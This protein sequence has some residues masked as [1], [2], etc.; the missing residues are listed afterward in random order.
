MPLL[1][2]VPWYLDADGD[3]Y[4]DLAQVVATSS[5]PVPGASAAGSDCDDANASFHPHGAEVCDDGFDQDCDGQDQACVGLGPVGSSGTQVR[6]PAYAGLGASIEAA[7]LDGD[8]VDELL[9]GTQDWRG[10]PAYVSVNRTDVTSDAVARLPQW[11]SRAYGLDLNRDGSAELVLTNEDVNGFGL[12]GSVASPEPLHE[13]HSTQ[14]V[15][16]VEAAD[17]TGDGVPELAVSTWSGVQG[18]LTVFEDPLGAMEVLDTLSL[19]TR[20][21]GHAADLDGDGIADWLDGTGCWWQ[22]P[23]PLRDWL[24]CA[25]TTTAIA[26]DADG[27]GRPDVIGAVGNAVWVIP[28]PDRT[29]WATI[30]LHEAAASLDWLVDANASGRPWV[31]VSE[32]SGTIRY[33]EPIPGPGTWEPYGMVFTVAALGAG[34]FDG[35]GAMDLALGRPSATLNADPEAGEVWVSWGLFDAAR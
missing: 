35:D 16:T 24:W 5:V 14:M 21:P 26:G 1:T 3:G 18:S 31:A 15:S 32:A 34:D 27:D 23:A 7:D 29:P 30:E 25:G 13:L 19:W 2:A 10:G 22:G 11:W 12:Y 9:A 8:G 33:V 17:F 20:E 4:G 28:S 6:G